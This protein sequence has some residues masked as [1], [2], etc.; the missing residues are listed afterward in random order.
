LNQSD[1]SSSERTSKYGKAGGFVQAL[2]SPRA[3]TQA[4]KIWP[5]GTKFILFFS[6]YLAYKRIIFYIKIT[7]YH[8]S[9]K[10]ESQNEDWIAKIFIFLLSNGVFPMLLTENTTND[11]C[12]SNL[13]GAW[14]WRCMGT[15]RTK[16]SPRV[17]P[18]YTLWHWWRS[19]LT[20]RKLCSNKFRWCF[21]KQNYYL[22]NRY[23]YA[24]IRWT[25][26]QM[27]LYVCKFCGRFL[28]KIQI[29]RM[30]LPLSCKHIFTAD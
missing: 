29:F 8:L 4:S 7:T 12:Q 20:D 30:L 10:F 18:L 19:G 6:L 3:A 15:Q 13:R 1:F 11:T 5:C 21:Y 23:I 25:I 28:T 14:K 9:F 27:Q 26:A 24:C 16:E 2:L 22:L 17:P